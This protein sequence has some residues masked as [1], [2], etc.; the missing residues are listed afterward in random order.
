MKI[1]RNFA[2]AAF[3]LAAWFT[4]AGRATAREFW[5]ST[6][7]TG[8]FHW[9]WASGKMNHP[10]DGS[11]QRNFDKN[12]NSLP[13]N[14]IV[15]L[16]PGTYRTKGYWGGFGIK[17]GQKILGSGMEATVLQFPPGLHV[18]GSGACMIANGYPVTDVEIC[19]LTCDCNALNHLD[20]YSGIVLNGTHLAVRRVKVINCAHFGGN[21]EAWGIELGM[22]GTG[23]TND[24]I[25]DCEVSHFNYAGGGGISSMCINGS[26]VMRHNRALLDGGSFGFDAPPGDVLIEG[27]YVE[28]AVSGV[29]GD[30]AGMT[31]A[32]VVK[33]TF[34]NCNAVCDLDNLHACNVTFAFNNIV[35]SNICYPQQALGFVFRADRG[36]WYSNIV[37]YG[38]RLDCSTTSES[39]EKD[40]V[41][42]RKVTGL[43]IIN[44]FVARDLTNDI[45]HC[46]N[47]SQNDNHDLFGNLRRDLNMPNA[48]DESL[49]YSNRVAEVL[50]RKGLSMDRF[51]ASAGGVS[52]ADL[53]K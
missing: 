39:R 51:N 13:A 52:P 31:N 28:A 29:H 48:S 47:V 37:I 15:H 24:V 10:L 45:V 11:T 40:F 8:N 27:N 20:T 7:A 36:A 14:S 33:N 50:A 12:M 26:G 5:I 18:G 22:L 23:S 19:D 4:M 6:N 44:N 38:N 16:S 21:S 25:E 34:K 30:M 35:V 42:A 3:F 41:Y 9:L 49:Y 2:L 1:I 32:T 46:S 17:T 43:A 53:K